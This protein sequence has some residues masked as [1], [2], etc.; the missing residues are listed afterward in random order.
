MSFHKRKAE[1]DWSSRKALRD[2]SRIDIKGMSF[3]S[4]Y[5]RVPYP[6]EIKRA[7]SRMTKRALL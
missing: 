4:E 2:L 1:A 6:V 5:D 3:K 7:V